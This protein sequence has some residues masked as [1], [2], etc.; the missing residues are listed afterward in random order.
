M[1]YGLNQKK[2]VIFHYTLLSKGL[3][4]AN[5]MDPDQT[6]PKGAV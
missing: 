4:M 3:Y 6:A 2:K 5:N 1:V